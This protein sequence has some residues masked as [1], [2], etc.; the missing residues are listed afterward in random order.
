MGRHVVATVGEVAPGTSKLVT[1]KG[2]EIGVFNIKGEYLHS[3]IRAPTKAPRC[4]R[5]SWSAS[6]NPTSRASI[7]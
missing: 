7:G 1:V 3:P 2:R 4:A 6:R 5:A